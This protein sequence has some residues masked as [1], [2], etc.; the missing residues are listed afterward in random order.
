MPEEEERG[1]GKTFPVIFCI[2]FGK[3]PLFQAHIIYVKFWELTLTLINCH[4]NDRYCTPSISVLVAVVRN[5]L[6]IVF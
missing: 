4:Y 6:A 2:Q 1:G 3:C 5:E